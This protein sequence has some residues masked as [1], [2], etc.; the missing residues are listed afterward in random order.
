[1]Q[2]ETLT[3]E[4]KIDTEI[5][6]LWREADTA[7]VKLGWAHDSIMRSAGYEKHYEGRTRYHW[8]TARNGGERA[9]YT[10]AIAAIE[11]MLA[12]LDP[13]VEYPMNPLTRSFEP[14]RD[15]RKKLDEF[16]ERTAALAEIEAKIT[17]RN[18]A[19]RGWSRFFLVTSSKG[20]IHSS[21]H[22]STCRPT[23]TYGWLPMLSGRTE[24]D[25]VAEFGPALCSVCYPS[26]PVEM[27][28]GFI[29]K[30]EANRRAES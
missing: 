17:E 5:A 30:A 28:G 8:R 16:N 6:A 9:D 11:E 22:C 14:I 13:A 23:T 18:Q 4:Q 15:T 12:N 26:A 25:C 7:T 10:M 19:Y 29:T 2:T 21:M 3:Y 24:A 1:M 20:H 27:V